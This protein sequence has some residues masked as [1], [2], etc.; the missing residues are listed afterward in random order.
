M[1]KRCAK[2]GKLKDNS[3]FNKQKATKDGLQSWCKECAFENYKKWREKHRKRHRKLKRKWQRAN[4]TETTGRTLYGKKR[5][6]PKGGTCELCNKECDKEGKRLYYH[7]W[8]DNNMLKGIW[9]CY[10]CHTLIENEEE[11]KALLLKW[12]LLEAEIDNKA[13]EA[14]NQININHFSF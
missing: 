13:K 5:K 9:V 12:H 7:H 6:R 2:C 4:Q 3:E 10:K 14:N 11:F 8:D 1:K